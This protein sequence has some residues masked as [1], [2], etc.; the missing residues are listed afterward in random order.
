V[1]DRRKLISEKVKKKRETEIEKENQEFENAVGASPDR[2]AI[3]LGKKPTQ[4]LARH[5]AAAIRRA[6]R[7]KR[8]E[9]GEHSD[10][11]SDYVPEKREEEE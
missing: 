6:Q 1:N 4:T 8:H 10:H 7:E 5:E 2:L 9:R 3:K 11:N